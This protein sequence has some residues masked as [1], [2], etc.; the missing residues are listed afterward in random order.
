MS[1]FL[2]TFYHSIIYVTVTSHCATTGSTVSFF[3]DSIGLLW[4]SRKLQLLTPVEH[5]LSTVFTYCMT[6]GVGGETP[7][8]LNTWN[9]PGRWKECHR[10][11]AIDS[12]AVWKSMNL[13]F[14]LIK[15]RGWRVKP[16]RFVFLFYFFFSS[17]LLA[18]V[19]FFGCSSLIF[20]P[21]SNDS[22][23]FLLV[24]S[25]Y[26]FLTFISISAQQQSESLPVQIAWT[27][28]C[29]Q[30]RVHRVESSESLTL[31]CSDTVCIFLCQSELHKH[32]I[33]ISCII[34]NRSDPGRAPQTRQKYQLH[35]EF[36]VN[37]LEH[38]KVFLKRDNSTVDQVEQFDLTPKKKVRQLNL[39]KLMKI[40]VMVI[41]VINKAHF[42]H[43][44]QVWS[45][46]GT[47]RVQSHSRL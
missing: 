13:N 11:V 18:F 33:I 36:T 26:I 34:D 31:G 27:N 8:A 1:Y 30:N 2:A 24:L 46:I 15:T 45:S 42:E 28:C 5:L 32:A 37:N 12:M 21:F 20:A 19:F 23:L 16:K 9:Q 40:T 44:I 10:E 3:P 47:I 38:L 7:T 4:H 17:S 14:T 39:T 35:V 29:F 6:Q 25:P 22:L 43:I 41:P